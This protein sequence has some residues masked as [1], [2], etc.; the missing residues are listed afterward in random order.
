MKKKITII[1][2]VIMLCLCAT[3]ALT[4]CDKNVKALYKPTNIEYD[5]ERITWTKVDLAEYYTVSINGGESKRVNTNLFT[6]ENTENVEFDV[7]V[8]SHIKGKSYSTSKHFIPL[9]RIESI[10]VSNDGV[11]SWS[12]VAGAGAYRISVNGEILVTDLTEPR[13]EAQAGSNRIKVRAVVPNDTS[14]YSS[15]SDEKQVFVNTA[16]SNINYDGERISW[17]GNAI[18]YEV[19]VN[20]DKQE[21]NGN[22]MLFNSQNTNFSVSVKALGDHVTSFDSKTTEENFHYLAAARNLVVEDGILSWD[23]VDGAEGYEVR[24][25]N[26]VQSQRVTEAT[27]DKLTAGTSLAVEVKPFNNSGKYFSSWSEVKSIYIL[28][29]PVVSWNS[30]LELD[31]QANNN[32]TW[33]I[34][35]GANGYAVRLEKDGNVTVTDFPLAQTAFAY[36]YS[37]VGTYKVSVKAIAAT[38]DDYYDSKYSDELIVER[39]AAPRAAGNNYITSDATDLSK[40]FTVNYMAVSG[41][42]GYQLYKDGVLLEGKFSTNLAITDADVADDEI[43]AQQNYSYVVRSMG[44]V[45]TISGKKYVTLPSLTVSSLSFNV[46]VQAMPTEL[47]MSG[48]NASWLPV[49]GNNGYGV[50][51]G[52]TVAT[53]TATQFNLQTLKAG[54]YEVSVC[55]R[56]NGGTT[57]ASNYTASITV[58]RLIAPSNITISY[59][60]GEGQLDYT[61]VQN[62]KSYQVFLDESTQSIPEDS[63]DNMYQ[64]IRETGTVVHMVAVANYF[65]DLGTIYY[66]TSEASPTKQFIRLAAPVF[67]EGVFSNN[68]E[69]VWN[70]PSNINTAEYTP[71][72]EVYESN[73]MQTGGVQNG[74]RFNIEFLDG[75]KSYTFRVK[76]V[77]NNTKYL[78]SAMSDAITVYK[79]ATPTITIKDGKYTWQGVTNASG[80]VLEIDGVRVDT[81]FHVSGSEYAYTPKYSTIGNHT[82]KLH[83]VGDGRQ[84]VNSANHTFTQV[85]KACLAPEISYGYSAQQFTNGGSIVVN[86]TT[87]SANANGYQYEIAGSSITSNELTASKQIENTGSY[88]V[89]VKALGGAF[90][91]ENVYYIDSPYA[92]G[93][94]G[95]TINL[96]APPTVSSFSLNSDGAVKWATITGAIGYDYQI[97]YDDGEYSA[98]QHTG[99]AS[100]NPIANYKNYKTIK[101]RVWASGNGTNVI[102]S[103][104]V[105]FVWNNPNK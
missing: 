76:A 68:I 77:G 99:T 12:D 103:A 61:E 44:A 70:T 53:A 24:V 35:N 90:D 88:V 26:V 98:I 1:F 60:T 80:Y 19:T 92:G 27:Y 40:G 83:A 50:R 74:T 57:L 4:A 73:V 23:A 91:A 3:F 15:W 62:A 5:G 18:K 79:L 85:V 34:V 87:Q 72:Y 47:T 31:G 58:Q 97:A 29:T 65:N 46:T 96:L 81:E 78:D 21:I 37:E 64:Y 105:E 41:A 82:V 55:T 66:M 9:D 63:F 30:D 84:T 75:G 14:Y 2:G 28:E 94:S 49:S 13:Y 51:Y 32:Y 10:T 54:S 36:A 45:K 7:K 17:M 42:S 11:L 69:M 71:T 56:G 25:N 95:Y 39:L 38:T 6:F 102:T 20:G 104:W 101:I 16:P 8:S 67:P 43:Y 22:N 86:I 59:G 93:G 33:N 52:G 48:F 100:L 89:R